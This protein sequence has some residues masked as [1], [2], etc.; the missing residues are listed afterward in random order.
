MNGMLVCLEG[1]F[2]CFVVIY[3]HVLPPTVSAGGW[4][5]G[6]FGRRMCHLS[7]LQV[8]GSVCELLQPVSDCYSVATKPCK[9]QRTRNTPFFP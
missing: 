5:L 8:H 9:R 2:I 6:N 7:S 1:L 3:R 4:L